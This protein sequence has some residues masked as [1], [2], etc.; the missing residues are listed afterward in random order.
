MKITAC[1]NKSE[2]TYLLAADCSRK[3]CV[4]K[5]VTQLYKIYPPCSILT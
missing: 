1:A 4:L 3:L 5:Q 2:T